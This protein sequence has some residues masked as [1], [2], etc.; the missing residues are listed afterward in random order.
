MSALR[1]FYSYYFK[2]ELIETNPT[3]LIDMPKLHEKE[4]IRLEID[5][6]A[7]LLDLVEEGD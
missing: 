5:E 1:T 3:L 6:V 4:I 7:K 2:K